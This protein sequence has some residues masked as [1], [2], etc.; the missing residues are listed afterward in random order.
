MQDL[1]TRSLKLFLATLLLSVTLLKALWDTQAWPSPLSHVSISLV[2]SQT[3]ALRWE[4]DLGFRTEIFTLYHL[5]YF[6]CRQLP[7]HFN[8]KLFS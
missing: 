1:E 3:Q 7:I 5:F 6:P 2:T 8:E 4:Y